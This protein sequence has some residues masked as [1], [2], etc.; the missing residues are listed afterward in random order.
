MFANGNAS[1][2]KISIKYFQQRLPTQ[3]TMLV[4]KLPLVLQQHTECVEMAL[5][6]TLTTGGLATLGAGDGLKAV[7]GTVDQCACTGSNY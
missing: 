1:I 2:I 4:T 7:A 6:T 5:D 3:N